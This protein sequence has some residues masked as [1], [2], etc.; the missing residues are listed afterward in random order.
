MTNFRTIK[1][2]ICNAFNWL[3]GNL[4]KEPLAD[5]QLI[6]HAYFVK[7]TT[8]VPKPRD[9]TCSNSYGQDQV[10]QQEEQ[11]AGDWY[12]DNKISVFQQFVVKVI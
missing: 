10:S 9:A 6:K 4:T 8:V 1:A 7:E 3:G 12:H 11:N 2:W 5:L